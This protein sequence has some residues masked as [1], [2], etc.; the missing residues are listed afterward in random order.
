MIY[1]NRLGERKKKKGFIFKKTELL[2]KQKN[3]KKS[4]QKIETSK[5]RTIRNLFKLKMNSF[6][7]WGKKIF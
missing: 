4:K 7:F 6:F 2:C 3:L 1:E 5:N